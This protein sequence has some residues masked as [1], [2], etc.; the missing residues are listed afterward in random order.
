MPFLI[1]WDPIE[2]KWLLVPNMF[3][4]LFAARMWSE[5]KGT[6][7][8]RVIVLAPV[9]AATMW[10]ANLTVYAVPAHTQLSRETM[11]G[12]CVGQHLQRADL[13]LS[14]SW[15]FAN[16]MSY[17]YGRDS[18]DVIGETLLANMD[19]PAAFR[20]MSAKIKQRQASG[21][22]VYMLD[23]AQ[24]GTHNFDL[25]KTIAHISTDELDKNFPGTSAFR[26][27]D[28]HFRKVN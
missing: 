19:K 12:D 2:T 28:L 4:A 7:F 9:A 8:R 24:T 25:L 27:Y 17:K 11:A 26:C 21:G 22:T 20:S 10:V 13:Y 23:P 6:P 1:W 5:S 14:A 18:L 16:Y 15:Y 3:I